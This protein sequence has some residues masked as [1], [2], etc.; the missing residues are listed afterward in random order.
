VAKS[1]IVQEALGTKVRVISGNASAFGIYMEAYEHVDQPIVLD[2]IDGLHKNPAGIRLLKALCQTDP[3]RT[4][5]WTTQ[6]PELVRRGIPRR[7]NTTSPVVL[8]ANDWNSVGPNLA[9]VED[10]MHVLEFDP[11]A[12]EVH[13]HAARWY[14]DQEVFDFVGEYLAAIEGHS[15]RLYVRAADL[16][17]AGMD[18][19][20]AVLQ[21]CFTGTTL[22]VA[23]LKTDPRFA[24]EE[25]RVRAFIERGHGCRASYFNHAR[26]IR[27]TGETSKIVLQQTARPQ[28]ASEPLGLMDLLRQRHKELGEG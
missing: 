8:I 12:D 16:K 18:W 3:I 25:D 27:P 23:K 11:P 24:T 15:L 5:S 1:T 28:A 26:R 22:V 6:A 14:W 2:D 20:R 17:K 21:S 10:R 7:F 13:R 19:K 4:I 9:A